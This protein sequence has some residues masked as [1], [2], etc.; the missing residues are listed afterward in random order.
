[1]IFT[2]KGKMGP[3][4]K[5]MARAVFMA[6]RPVRD[7]SKKLQVTDHPQV[8]MWLLKTFVIPAAMYGAQVWASN[9]LDFD[10][11]LKSRVQSHILGYCKQL[12]GV[13]KST[14]A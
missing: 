5:H 11:C 2:D 1:M 8:M 4:Q 13:K 12:L 9:L 7:K 10:V 3:A 14:H 6:A